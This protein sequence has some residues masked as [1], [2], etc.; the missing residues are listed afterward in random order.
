MHA[1]SNCIPAIWQV[2]TQVKPGYRFTRLTGDATNWGR[3]DTLYDRPVLPSARIRIRRK[4]PI[5]QKA[6]TLYPYDARYYTALGVAF[7]REHRFAEAES[8]LRKALAL[9]DD[10]D[11]V[12]MG[13]LS[14]VVLYDEKRFPKRWTPNAGPLRQTPAIRFAHPDRGLDQVDRTHRSGSSP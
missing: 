4:S 6:I 8:A 9:D 12:S 1:L 7:E 13:G 10:H 5:L 11:W 14:R 2:F 3:A